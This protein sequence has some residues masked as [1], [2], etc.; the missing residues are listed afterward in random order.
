ML[1]WLLLYGILMGL[2]LRVINH[3]RLVVAGSPSR[4][5]LQKVFGW[6]LRMM[7]LAFIIIH[8][9]HLHWLW[10]DCYNAWWND[11]FVEHSMGA[12]L[13]VT[14]P[15]T[16]ALY[17][18]KEI[19]FWTA[20]DPH[21]FQVYQPGT[22][23]PTIVRTSMRIPMVW[24]VAFWAWILTS[25]WL[26]FYQCFVQGYLLGQKP[27][28]AQGLAGAPRPPQGCHWGCTMKG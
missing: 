20:R 15:L 27:W 9:F 16:V 24:F 3:G 22:G 6:Y 11:Y 7:I 25:P 18:L 12:W 23:Q 13:L 28:V 19:T 17:L 2:L 14:C 26:P 21:E 8:G 4:G 1:D 10:P 5:W